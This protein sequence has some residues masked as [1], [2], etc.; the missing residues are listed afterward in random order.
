M[1]FVRGNYNFIVLNAIFIL[2]W[3]I[4][5]MTGAEHIF[6]MPFGL[7]FTNICDDLGVQ[8]VF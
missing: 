4:A 7:F 5:I 1:H 6:L 2:F 3:P 8:D